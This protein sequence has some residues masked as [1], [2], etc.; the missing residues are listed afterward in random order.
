[1]YETLSIGEILQQTSNL[2]SLLIRAELLFLRRFD[3]NSM[4]GT[5]W[6]SCKEHKVSSQVIMLLKSQHIDQPHCVGLQQ[7]SIVFLCA[8]GLALWNQ[9]LTEVMHVQIIVTNAMNAA[10]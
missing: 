2:V 5:F 10:H 6:L 9:V 8:L 4:T 7:V 3:F 1:M